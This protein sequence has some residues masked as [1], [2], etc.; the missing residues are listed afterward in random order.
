MAAVFQQILQLSH[1]VGK[2]DNFFHLGGD[3]LR[4]MRALARLSEAWGLVIPATMLFR[5][6]TVAGLA[7]ELA[8]LTANPT[9]LPTAGSFQQCHNLGVTTPLEPRAEQGSF[10]L[11]FAQQR[12]WFLA[13]FEGANSAYNITGAARLTGQLKP[14]ALA[15]AI[16]EIVRRH[17]SLRTR[18]TEVDSQPS[19]IVAAAHEMAL[20]VED[21]ST[22]GAV[23]QATAL[24]AVIQRESSIAFDL[25]VAPLLRLTLVKLDEEEHLL[26]WVFHHIVSDGWSMAVF[27]TELAVLYE[28]FSQVGEQDTA[29]KKLVFVRASG[30]GEDQGV[31]HWMNGGGR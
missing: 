23:A 20:P 2:N 15:Q 13:Q 21:L 17:E 4:G 1:P 29:G 7:N 8:C 3:S 25:E 5:N 31:W 9:T 22:L 28:A 11:S 14:S 10:P 24:S 19:Q 27:K 6:P 18:F 26:I 30:V 16:N 12:L